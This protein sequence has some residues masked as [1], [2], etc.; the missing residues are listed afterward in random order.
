MKTTSFVWRIEVL[1]V[2]AL[3]W[4]FWPCAARAA[5]PNLQKGIAA[6]EAFEFQE[7]LKLL[8]RV[9]ATEGIGAED[10]ARAH[11]YLGLTR[12]TLGDR[13]GAEREFA[14]AVR[15]HYDCA[16]PPDT[17][18]KI[19]AVF[20]AVKKT[21]P[22]PK[23]KD[24]TVT[25]GPGPGP[26]TGPGPPP[27]PGPRPPP[28][29]PPPPPPPRGRLWT[30]IAA[31][32]GGAALIAGGTFGYLASQSK[33]D[34]DKEIWADKAQSLKES[35]ES[36]ALTANILFGVG[37]GL[38]ATALVLFFVEGDAAPASRQTVNVTAGPT[39]FLATVRF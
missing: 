26:G 23:K 25:I 28:P 35:A 29:A 8:E 22:P 39:G 24:D 17:A 5:N 34:F 3:L 11:L 10:K 2:V 12:F 30:W 21:I 31:G 16:P 32:A 18:P 14:E 33:A 19:V 13:A 9:V 38:L 4:L 1:A 7:A 15:A 20:E 27:G 37:G 36:R 6:Y